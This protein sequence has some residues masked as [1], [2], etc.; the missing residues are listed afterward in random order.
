METS[1]R[2]LM[3]DVAMGNELYDAENDRVISGSE[4]DDMIRKVVFEKLGL[5]KDATPRQ[6]NRALKRE[7]AL[8]LF[9][10]LEEVIDVKVATGWHNSEFFNE[11]VEDRNL[12]DGD[13][14]TFY[15]DKEIFLDVAHVSGSHHDHIVQKLGEGAPFTVPTSWYCV[16]VGTDI[17]LFLTG[18]R[19]WADFI[20]AVAKAF[21][22][23]IQEEIYTAF[24]G[25]AAQIPA[26][27][28]FNKTGQIIANTKSIFDELIEDVEIANE[29]PVVIMG[30]KTA[31]K[32]LTGWADVNWIAESQK[33]DVYR[34]G[35]M[36]VYE[37]TVLVEIPQRFAS[38]NTG[39]KLV[40]N[41]KLYIMPQ[42][43]N[44]F[45]KFV[46]GGETTLEVT[47]I[48]ETMNDQQTYEVHR[49]MGVAA[50]IS[51]YFGVWTIQ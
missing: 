17:R 23:Q 14:Q 37:G 49:R 32:K 43:D 9:E 7:S 18:R 22:K 30:T 5:S 29:S 15:T 24:T 25:A 4:A 31:L 39:Q 28:Q 20:D 35:I 16:K 50:V 42:V 21:V 3:F 12:A 8:E 26:T 13:A 48:G 51:R 45:V 40:D 2:N 46:D 10:L 19:S 11:F 47:E 36:G 1:V 27:S 41:T 38:N 6:I 44:K 33:E 34:H